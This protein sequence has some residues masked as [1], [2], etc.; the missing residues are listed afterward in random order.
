MEQKLQEAKRSLI[1]SAHAVRDTLIECRAY[2]AS[3]ELSRI[4]T[5]LNFQLSG[6]EYAF[7]QAV[8]EAARVDQAVEAAIARRNSG[9]AGEPNA[10]T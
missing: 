10:G 4:L 8:R 1:A 9:K 5:G 7:D 6:A 2:S 3:A